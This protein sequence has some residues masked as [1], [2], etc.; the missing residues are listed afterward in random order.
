M[1]E[2]EIKR[3]QEY[4]RNRKKWSIIQ[5]IVI[6]LLAIIALG[7]FLIY[8]KMNDT[9]YIEYRETSSVDYKV[10]YEDNEYFDEDW[11][12]RD[13][14]YISELVEKMVA[15]FNYKLDMD[16]LGVGFKYKYKVDATLLIS[17]K[18]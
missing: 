11:I 13:Q 4:K 7:S 18:T 12:E 14:E 1:S 3:R 8:D 17:D 6:A 16:T 10:K 5:I 9:F 15:D 2:L